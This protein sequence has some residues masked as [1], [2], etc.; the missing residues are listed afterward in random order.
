[1]H[2]FE[3]PIDLIGINPF[4]W[5]P[6]DILLDLFAQAGTSKGPIPICGTVNGKAYTQTLVRYQGHWRLYINTAMLNHSPQRIGETIDL[7]IAFDPADRTIAPHPRLVQALADCPD[8]K[9]VFDGLAAS[10][11]KE[12]VRYIASLKT[13]E[14]IARNVARAIDFLL[15][16]GRFVGRDK[17]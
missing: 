17:A 5:V 12:I 16:K 4:V 8:A 11:Q 3:A 6:D 2:R 15:G 9:R 14:S 7:T 1:M 10:R 13:E